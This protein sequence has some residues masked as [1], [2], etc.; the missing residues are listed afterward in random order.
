MATNVIGHQMEPWWRLDDK[1]VMVT[2]ASSGLGREFCVDL[3]KAGCRIIAASRRTD[4]LKSLC[5]EINQ[6]S[7]SSAS[8]AVAVELDVARD[9]K[10]IEASVQKAWDMFGCVHALINNAGVRGTVSSTLELSEEEWDD[11]FATNLKGTW[12]VSKFV[13][14]RMRDANIQGSVV[15]IT[16][17]SGLDRVLSRGSLAYSA[18]KAAVHAATKVMALELGE[19][20]IKVNSIAPGIFKSEITYKLMEKPWLKNYVSPAVPLKD[21]GTTDPA[22]TSLVRYL[23]HD[24]SNY[25]TGNIFVVDSGLT[26]RGVPLQSSL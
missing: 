7:S 9:S 10:A 5:D 12:L 6:L 3:A 18:S 4:R 8:R 15:N 19:F 24:E 23:I 11:I 22:L 13:C 17:A 16:S 26:L 25:V 2:G 21:L 1:V 20:K 14:T